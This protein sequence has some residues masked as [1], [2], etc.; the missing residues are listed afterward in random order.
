MN[1]KTSLKE[2]TPDS[3]RMMHI[4]KICHVPHLAYFSI[5][6]LW[7]SIHQTFNQTLL[8]A[9]YSFLV[10]FEMVTG[11]NSCSC[12]WYLGQGRLCGGFSH[13]R[14]RTASYNLLYPTMTR[15]WSCWFYSNHIME[16]SV[17]TQHFIVLLYHWG[18]KSLSCLFL[19][20][21]SSKRD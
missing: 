2:A 7:L 16:S 1:T 5:Q 17:H 8:P 12:W 10:S 9:S 11:S 18:K 14:V 13:W 3:D 20:Q 19:C 6:T 21:T 15:W 4:D